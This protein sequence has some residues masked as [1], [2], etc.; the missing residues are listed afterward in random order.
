T[1]LS[2]SDSSF[3][4]GFD[5]GVMKWSPQHAE[6]LPELSGLDVRCLL[7][8]RDGTI[9]IGTGNRGLLRWNSPPGSRKLRES[10]VPDKFVTAIAEDHTGTIWAGST[11]GGLYSVNG[12]RVEQFGHS[13]GFRSPYIYAGYVDGK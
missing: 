6:M 9:W 5:R 4:I 13:E 2:Q 8:A 12:D 10:G 1:L 7:Q 3:L 11:S